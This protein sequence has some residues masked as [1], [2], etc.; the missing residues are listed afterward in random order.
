MTFVCGC[1]SVLI[2]LLP[3]LVDCDERVCFFV[4]IG[5]NNNYGGCF[6]YLFSDWMVGSIS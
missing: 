2:D 4:D 1:Y 6:F 3:D 5:F